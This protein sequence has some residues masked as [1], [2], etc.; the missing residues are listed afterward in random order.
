VAGPR[1][2]CGAFELQAGDTTAATLARP[3]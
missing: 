2:D 3:R 1:V